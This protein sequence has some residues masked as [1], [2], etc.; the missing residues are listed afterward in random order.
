[1]LI[2]HQGVESVNRAY[3]LLDITRFDSAR[4]LTIR[5]VLTSPSFPLAR[6][7]RFVDALT[8]PDASCYDSGVDT[9][10][11]PPAGSPLGETPEGAG[12][13]SRAR[14][15]LAQDGGATMTQETKEAPASVQDLKAALAKAAAAGDVDSILAL[16]KQV[17]AQRVAEAKAA[18]ERIVKERAGVEHEMLE[19]IRPVLAKFEPAV[20]RLGGTARILWT[21]AESLFTAA[22]TSKV[23]PK[24]SGAG[25]AAKKGTWADRYGITLASIYEK[26]ASAEDRAAHDGAATNTERW[27]IKTKVAKRAVAEG[28]LHEVA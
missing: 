18:H 16:A 20:T 1:M 25:A 9:D 12:S 11:R 7:E 2:I 10:T 17:E 6:R 22:I 27:N 21:P 13:A 3:V 19:A 8:R 5:A 15:I 23:E 24:S 4:P 14:I 26:F 28:L